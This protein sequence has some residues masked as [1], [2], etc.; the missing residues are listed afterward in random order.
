MLNLKLSSK[1]NRREVSEETKKAISAN[2]VFPDLNYS[3]TK[4]GGAFVVSQKFVDAN[5]LASNELNFSLGEDSKVYV[6]VVTE[7]SKFGVSLTKSNKSKTGKKSKRFGNN[8]LEGYLVEAGLITEAP[9]SKKS[10]GDGIIYEWAVGTKAKFDLIQVNSELPDGYV[11]AYT[12]EIS[13]KETTEDD[14]ELA[15]NEIETET[16]TTDGVVESSEEDFE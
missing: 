4:N 3:V 8:I 2:R 14:S 5:N 12:V 11:A 7:E 9:I 16:T 1:A 6:V 13:T 15:D 10:V